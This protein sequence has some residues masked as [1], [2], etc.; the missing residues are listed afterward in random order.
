MDSL[1]IIRQFLAPLNKLEIDYV[2]T[3][4]VASIIYGNPRLTHDIDLVINIHSLQVTDFLAQFD[5]DK[6]YVPP[7]EVFQ[8][9][10]K[11]DT[12]GHVNIIHIESGFKADLYFAGKSDLQ[13]WALK[14]YSETD[15]FNMTFRLAPVEYVII[16]KLLFYR[17]AKMQKHIID[18]QGILEHS[19][20]SINFT[21]LN[22]YIK[23]YNLKK[24]WKMIEN[25]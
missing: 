14:N 3:G 4:S 24:L 21:I 2:V 5:P 15:F 6:F 17:E 10:L 11:R 12:H 25:K 9:E 20:G 23:E 22:S 13:M 16:Q 18:I 1:K 8:I 7:A 19:F